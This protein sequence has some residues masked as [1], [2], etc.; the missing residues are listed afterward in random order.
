MK[1]SPL[2]GALMLIP[3][4]L[5]A[6]GSRADIDHIIL[7]INNLDKGI[8]EFAERTGVTPQKGGEHPTGRTQNALVSLGNG[9]YLEILAPKSSEPNPDAVVPYRDLVVGGWALHGGALE[10]LLSGLKG[11][12][13]TPVGPIPGS[14]KQPNG[15]LL[16]WRTGNASGPGLSLAPFLI[17][18]S[19][20]S[21][22]PSTTSPG[23]C[24]LDGIELREPDPGPLQRFFTAVGYSGTV[25]RGE[26]GMIV[27]LTCPKGRVVFATLE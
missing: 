7:A 25:T 4:P 3:A 20:A 17:E 16:E 24:R 23:G 14:R 6:Q 19:A 1:F 2:L 5:P 10:P 9:H 27:R 12:G 21:P 11:A 22:H 26:R 18:W 13:F 15:S 8:A